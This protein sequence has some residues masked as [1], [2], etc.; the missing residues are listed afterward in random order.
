MTTPPAA[1][2]FD[3][4]GTL[5][6]WRSSIARDVALVLEAHGVDTVDPAAF[7]ASWRARYRPALDAVRNG[8]RG[9]TLLDILHRENLDA[10][11]E[12]HGITTP[13][14]DER[15]WLTAAWTRLDP[16]P[17]VVDGLER[18]RHHL[19]LAALSNGSV[20]MM[21][22]LARYADLRW[23]AVLGAQPAGAYKPDPAVYLTAADW[24]D[25]EP[26]ACMLVAAHAHDTRAAQELG[27]RT[28]YVRRPREY[29]PDVAAEEPPAEADLVVDDL[30]ELADRLLD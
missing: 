27:L 2:L 25:V 16:W 28:A 9:F 20:G 22:R 1:L 19:L 26:G 12:A 4:F 8:E 29:G 11:L 5:V 14:D 7:A 18:L 23:H 21:A 10:T 17:D 15:S 30:G 13:G 3:V 24:L 6:D